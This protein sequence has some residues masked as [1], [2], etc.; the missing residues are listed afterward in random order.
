MLFFWERSQEDICCVVVTQNLADCYCEGPFSNICFS[1]SCW[2]L[3]VCFESHQGPHVNVCGCVTIKLYSQETS[4][5]PHLP[6]GAVAT[7]HAVTVHASFHGVQAIFIPLQHA[8]FQ[9]CAQSHLKFVYSSF[10][11]ECVPWSWGDHV[12]KLDACGQTFSSMLCIIWVKAELQNVDTPMVFAPIFLLSYPVGGCCIP[13]HQLI[14][15]T[16]SWLWERAP[17][18]PIDSHKGPPSAS[19]CWTLGPVTEWLHVPTQPPWAE[20]SCWAWDQSGWSWAPFLK[21]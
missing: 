16:R 8:V 10:P 15:V 7:S 9:F 3:T 21:L 6:C 11:L 20:V 19:V 18:I 1:H 5:G 4:G 14:Q 17:I 2:I 12:A 13:G